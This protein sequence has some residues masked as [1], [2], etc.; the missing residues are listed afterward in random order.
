MLLI[1]LSGCEQE[2]DSRT[3]CGLGCRRQAIA[4]GTDQRSRRGV[5][6]VQEEAIVVAITDREQLKVLEGAFGFARLLPH[7]EV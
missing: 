7:G 1:V 4:A 5:S 6:P 3:R 2:Q